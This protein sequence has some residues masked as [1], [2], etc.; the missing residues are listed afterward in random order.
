M[1]D[2]DAIK[3]AEQRGYAKGYAAGKRRNDGEKDGIADFWQRTFLTVLPT[4]LN[5]KT[6]EM[7]GVKVVTMEDRVELARRAA[8]AAA[9]AAAMR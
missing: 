1:A 3:A 9:A 8:N 4:L 6:W 2:D 7:D 5:G